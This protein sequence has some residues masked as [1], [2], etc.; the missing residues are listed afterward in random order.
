MPEVTALPA[1]GVVAAVAQDRSEE[2]QSQR[3]VAQEGM[4]S[5]RLLLVRVLLV[6]GAAVAAV[7]RLGLAAQVAVGTV[8]VLGMIR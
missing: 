5:H 8:R 2:I 1:Q 3:Q 6:P 7:I 4:A